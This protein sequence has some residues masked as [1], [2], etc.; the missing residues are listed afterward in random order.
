MA[1]RAPRIALVSASVIAPALLWLW[2]NARDQPA[3]VDPDGAPW[4][5]LPKSGMDATQ[6]STRQVLRLG[7]WGDG[8]DPAES[9]AFRCGSE[10]ETLP[11]KERY[12]AY[13]GRNVWR[14]Y[15]RVIF[16]VRGQQVDISLSES[17]LF[18]PPPPPTFNGQNVDRHYYFPTTRLQKTRHQ[19]ELIRAAW[20]DADL[21]H[22]PQ[23]ERF[24]RC[25]DGNPVFLEACID[26][27]YAA[28]FRNCDIASANSTSRLWQAFN[29]LLPPPPKPEWRD[30]AGNPI[31]D[32]R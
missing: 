22:A 23:D 13:I 20:N 18:E 31:P 32:N 14:P 12:V 15:W 2:W 5:G 16:D 19:L 25:G 9:L 8:R 11:T 30:A 27:R 24:D 29:D 4:I 3:P 10:S 1:I 7:F 6:Q 17:R 21:W 26:G 28:R